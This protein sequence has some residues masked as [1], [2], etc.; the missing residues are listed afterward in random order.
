MPTRVSP[1]RL[2]VS[3]VGQ[4]RAKDLL[5]TMCFQRLEERRV[6]DT[7]EEQVRPAPPVA[8]LGPALRLELCDRLRVLVG[9]ADGRRVIG[10]D[11]YRLLAPVGLDR[12]FVLR[13][14]P[15][16]LRGKTHGTGLEEFLPPRR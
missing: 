1:Y 16:P 12:S 13:C 10:S 8:L 14:Q 9:P 2:E 7:V 5:L 3:G 11:Q 6:V 15:A 4:D